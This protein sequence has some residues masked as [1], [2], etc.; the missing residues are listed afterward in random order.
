MQIVQ[1]GRF[2]EAWQPPRP[3]DPV[4]DGLVSASDESASR[5]A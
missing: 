1:L 3:K 2:E 4:E 5:R